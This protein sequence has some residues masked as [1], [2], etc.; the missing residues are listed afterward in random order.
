MLLIVVCFHVI[1]MLLPFSS[2]YVQ[3]ITFFS[4]LEQD[5]AKASNISKVAIEG[6]DN[7]LVED[8]TSCVFVVDCCIIVLLF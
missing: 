8:T 6:K 4:L 5:A 1:L 2:Y 3:S 7:K